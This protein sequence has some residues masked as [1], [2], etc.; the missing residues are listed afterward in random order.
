MDNVHLLQRLQEIGLAS[1]NLSLHQSRLREIQDPLT[2]IWCYLMFMAAKVEHQE[3]R[4]LAVYGLVILDLA[5]KH[6]SQ[7]W[8]LYD[9]LFCQQAAAGVM[10]LWTELNSAAPEVS[11]AS[12]STGSHAVL[13]LQVSGHGLTSWMFTI[14]PAPMPTGAK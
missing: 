6:G 5:R 13:L 2:W 7:G 8:L 14:P 9:G 4:E 3:T 12:R 11:S 1:Q 10:L